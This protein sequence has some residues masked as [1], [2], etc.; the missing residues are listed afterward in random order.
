MQR[1]AMFGLDSELLTMEEARLRH[2]ISVGS[3]GDQ[4][5]QA[6]TM[7]RDAIHELMNEIYLPA[8]LLPRLI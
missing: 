4:R 5:T 7:S 8:D 3:T 6:Q 1:S 2:H